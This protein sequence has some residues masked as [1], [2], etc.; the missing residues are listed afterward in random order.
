M[1]RNPRPSPMLCSQDSHLLSEHTQP[2]SADIQ[3]DIACNRKPKEMGWLCFRQ[4]RLECKDYNK[5][6]QGQY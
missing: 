3:N 4:N 5:T 6:R 2:E 1:E